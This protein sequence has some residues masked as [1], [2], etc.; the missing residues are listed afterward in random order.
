MEIKI[1]QPIGLCVSASSILD[2]IYKHQE[3]YHK[4]YILGDILHNEYVI[5][6]LSERGIKFIKELEGIVNDKYTLVVLPSHGTSPLVYEKLKKYNYIDLT[7]PK[8][9]KMHEFIINN[10]DKD[11]IFLGQPNHS[12]T[13]ASRD[14]DN[15]KV[16][17]SKKDID[18]LGELNNPILMCQ[19]T[20]NKDIFVEISEIL[21]EK[22]PNI[23]I[24]NTLCNIPL[25]RIININ[26][27]DCDLLLVIGSKTSSNANEISKSKPNS[28]IIGK[29]EE[30]DL[31]ELR[32]Y[33]KI[34]IASAS[35]TPIQQV[36]EIVEYIRKNA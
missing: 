27:T 5:N 20:F 7:C 13:V 32:K 3:K 21:K 25:D 9:K 35:S 16:I 30:I 17:S 11:I 33:K 10:S 23:V 24:N 31:D 26:S 36:D 28:M 4:I 19:T 1:I 2:E 14:Y 22:Y 29:V 12:E 15:V 8:I 34:A 18:K 6:Y